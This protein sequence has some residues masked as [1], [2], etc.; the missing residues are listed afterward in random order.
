MKRDIKKGMTPIGLLGSVNKI[1]SVDLHVDWERL[2]STG[3]YSIAIFF[4]RALC[5]LRG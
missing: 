3:E 5:V 1:E 2:K 4:L